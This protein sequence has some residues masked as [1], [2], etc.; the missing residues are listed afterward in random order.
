MPSDVYD[1]LLELLKD[2]PEL[3]TWLLKNLFHVEVPDYRF[4]DRYTTEDRQTRPMHS[5]GETRYSDHDDQASMG[6]VMEVA[7]DR[8][9]RRLWRWKRCVVL[10]E[11]ELDAPVRL[12]LFIPDPAI[13][14]W[15]Q[16]HIEADTSSAPLR[17]YVFT[18]PEMPRTMNVDLAWEHPA[19][20][21]LSAYCHATDPDVDD[22]FPAVAVAVR[23][24]IAAR[25]LA[26][27]D[28]M[29]SWLPEAVA[30]RWANYLLTAADPAAN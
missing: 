18:R 12:L 19:L 30:S 29:R 7:L 8:D 6:A 27:D 21:M 26:Y 3:P 14:S 22:M 20:I 5:E 10:L 15:Y 28:H 24:G 23:S 11:E 16:R 17:P 1:V 2:D 9:S 25:E 4:A 13:A